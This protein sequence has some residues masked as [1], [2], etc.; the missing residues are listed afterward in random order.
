MLA[1]L[2]RPRNG[3][4]A[5][6]PRDSVERVAVRRRGS[7]NSEV[8]LADTLRRRFV[9]DWLATL[10]T[11]IFSHGDAVELQALGGHIIVRTLCSTAL[12]LSVTLGACVHHPARPIVLTNSDVLHAWQAQWDALPAEFPAKPPATANWLNTQQRM[13]D[14]FRVCGPPPISMEPDIVLLELDDSLSLP[15]RFAILQKVHGRVVA[16]F[17]P[18]YFTIW[19]RPTGKCEAPGAV[20]ILRQLPGVKFAMPNRFISTGPEPSSAKKPPA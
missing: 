17:F 18:K 10:T 14:S 5:A 9:R 20:A 12:C 15:S 4:G 8:A 11:R 13:D 7:H 19:I 6:R 2:S 16:E 3:V 1:P